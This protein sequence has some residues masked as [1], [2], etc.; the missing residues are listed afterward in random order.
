MSKLF[1][2]NELF[3][4]HYGPLGRREALIM[5]RVRENRRKYDTM[6]QCYYAERKYVRAGSE[7]I[8]DELSAMWCDLF[9]PKGNLLLDRISREP[10]RWNEYRPFQVPKENK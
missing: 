3:K 2:L 10:D 6:R 5:R 8:Q 1:T 9:L 4:R 7:A